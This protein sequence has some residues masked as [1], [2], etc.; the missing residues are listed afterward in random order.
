MSG[1]TFG[2]VMSNSIVHHIP[3]PASVLAEMVRVAAPGG[4]LFVRDLLRLPVLNLLPERLEVPLN[5]VDSY[6][7]RIGNRE[8]LGVLRKDRGELA[9]EGEITANKDPISGRN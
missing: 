8:V 1:M 2:A 7:K 5:T 3:E 6:R 4:L 9:L